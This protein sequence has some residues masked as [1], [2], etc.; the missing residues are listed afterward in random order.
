MYAEMFSTGMKHRWSHRVY[1]DL[2]CGSGHALIRE[3]GLRVLTSPLIALGLR[4][5]FTKYIFC[6]SDSEQLAALRTRATRT[7]PAANVEYVPGDANQRVR[8]I[9]ALIPPHS[10]E[11]TALSFCFIDPFGL[12]IHFETIRRLGSGRPIDF[13]TL[14]ALGMDATRNWSTYLGPDNVK[15]DKF[16][17][18]SS[19][20][21]RWEIASRERKTPIR[22]LAE[23]YAARM[24]SLGYLNP[25]LERMIEVRTHDNNMRLYYLAFFSRNERGYEFWDQVRKYSTDQ[26]ELELPP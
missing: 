2:F 7:S 13:L 18:N 12:D 15:V 19:W 9:E 6:D 4:D 3:R 8:D 16:L 23:E 1:I 17:G 21:D 24:T 14:L 5:P 26:G 25:G 20:R 10:S 22:F 11:R